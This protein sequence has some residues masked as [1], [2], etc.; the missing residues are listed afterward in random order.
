MHCMGEGY[1]WLVVSK[2]VIASYRYLLMDLIVLFVYRVLATCIPAA[3]RERT[4]VAVYESQC[5]KIK[6]EVHIIL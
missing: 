6:V 2:M 5:I 1:V 4:L 3:G